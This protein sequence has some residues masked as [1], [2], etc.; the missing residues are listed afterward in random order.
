MMMH[1][2]LSVVMGSV[3]YGAVFV[4]DC[5]VSRLLMILDKGTGC[6]LV[7]HICSLHSLQVSAL[8]L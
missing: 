3:V 7:K 1:W 4:Q 5:F 6:S 8:P 2:T